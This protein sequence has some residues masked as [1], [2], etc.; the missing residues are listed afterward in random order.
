MTFSNESAVF[1]IL[2]SNG[3]FPDSD[4]D[5]VVYAAAEGFSSAESTV[6]ITRLGATR[7]P[8]KGPCTPLPQAVFPSGPD[9]RS[10]GLR[11]QGLRTDN[12]MQFKSNVPGSD[13]DSAVPQIEGLKEENRR[14]RLLLANI[15]SGEL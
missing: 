13:S 1:S 10:N 9:G 12:Q 5:D 11:A 2:R 15:T 3:P 7:R 8:T 6:D 14:L 4:M